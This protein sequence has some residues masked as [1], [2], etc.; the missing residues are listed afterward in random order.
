[1][2]IEKNGNDALLLN[3]L[4]RGASDQSDN[5]IDVDAV[6]GL[7]APSPQGYNENAIEVRLHSSSQFQRFILD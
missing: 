6:D 2:G 3:N 5:S 1:M 7:G 4:G